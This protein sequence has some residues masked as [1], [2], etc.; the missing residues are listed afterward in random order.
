M[1][2]IK[3]I[4]GLEPWE[5]MK[6]ASEGEPVAWR[7]INKK[8]CG[9]YEEWFEAKDPSWNFTSFEFAIID[10]STPDYQWGNDEIVRIIDSRMGDGWANKLA[11][12]LK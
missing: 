4:E 3:V 11:E 2:D 7:Y 10:T 9:G 5:V 1:S 8:V 6:R 12:S